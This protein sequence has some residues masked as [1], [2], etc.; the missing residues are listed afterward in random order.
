M[1]FIFLFNLGYSVDLPTT[2]ISSRG[3]YTTE[4]R[5]SEKGK[6]IGS[7]GIVPINNFVFGLSYGGEGIIGS[8]T[9][10]YNSSPGIQAKCGFAGPKFSMAIGYDSETYGTSPLGVYGVLGGDLSWKLI[11]YI[12]VGYHDYTKPFCGLEI[13]VLPSA[14]LVME[15]YLEEGNF[16]FNGG[17]RWIFEQQIMIEFDFKDV[18]SHQP[19]RALKFSYMGYI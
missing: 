12:G 14:I 16:L 8:G 18:F 3:S 10:K 7:I 17:I 19:I 11:P 5:I 2:Y 6:L 9:P 13:G 4:F 15:G 1:L